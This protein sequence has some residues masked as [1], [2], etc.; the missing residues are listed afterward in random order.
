MS[1]RWRLIHPG[2]CRPWRHRRRRHC[3]TGRESAASATRSD[4]TWASVPCWTALVE[5]RPGWCS[6]SIDQSVRTSTPH[7]SRSVAHINQLSSNPTHNTT[8]RTSLSLNQLRSLQLHRIW[9]DH[10]VQSSDTTRQRRTFSHVINADA[11][12]RLIYTF[13]EEPIFLIS[14]L[15]TIPVVT[16][17][18]PSHNND[19][20]FLINFRPYLYCTRIMQ[21]NLNATRRQAVARIADR[22]ASQ[23]IWGVT[24]RHRARDHSIAHMPFAIGGPLEPSLYLIL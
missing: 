10:M 7:H 6:S 21:M 22:T 8:T 2:T 23:H 19:N 24:W 9:T 5:C 12:S 16:V 17:G 11:S 4:M 13:A 20:N 14:T 3:R 18:R 15:V 1:A